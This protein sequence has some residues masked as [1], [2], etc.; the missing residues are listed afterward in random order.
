MEVFAEVRHLPGPLRADR[1]NE[2]CGE[3]TTV[4]SEV[5]SLLEH[6]DSAPTDML[7]ESSAFDDIFDD[8]AGTDLMPSCE[9]PDVIGGYRIKRIIGAG[10][11][12]VVYEAEQDKPRRAVAL[13]LVRSF[14]SPEAL[15][16]FELEGELLGRLRHPGIAR[17]FEAGTDTVG[18]LRRPFL[19]MELVVGANL[20]DHASGLDP[21]AKLDLIA[22][23]ADAVEHAHRRGV[24]HRDLK[25]GNILVDEAGQPVVLDFGIARVIDE[26][27]RGNSFATR[28]G[29]L[30]GTLPYM[31]PEQAAGDAEAVDTRTDVYALGAVAYELLAGR[32][33]I[34]T[35][36]MGLARAAE[37]VRDERPAPLSSL[38]SELGG[39][40]ETIV[41]CALEKDADRRYSSA[42]ELAADIRRFLSHK[43]ILARAPSR[44]YELKKFVRRH[45]V[46]V[47]LATAAALIL[48][49][50]IVTTT[51]GLVRAL[52]A[53]KLADDR[54][55]QAELALADAEA[56]ITFLDRMVDDS[57]RA[58]T[59]GRELTFSEALDQASLRLEEDV[60]DNP[61]V[62]ASIHAI[63]GMDYDTLEQSAKGL[64]HLRESWRLRQEH[65]GERHAETF[66]AAL[67]YGRVLLR[68]G[69]TDE[70]FEH[71]TQ[72][73]DLTPTL[74]DSHPNLVARLHFVHGEATMYR[75]DFDGAEKAMKMALEFYVE[76]GERGELE[77]ELHAGIA[78]SLRRQGR[79]REGEK[80]LREALAI[81]ARL[82]GVDSSQ[83][84]TFAGNL[85]INLKQQGRLAEAERMLRAAVEVK[86]RLFGA[87][88][89]GVMTH[90]CNLASLHL[91]L[92]NHRDAIEGLTAAVETHRRHL[93]DD[94]RNVGFPVYFLGRAHHEFGNYDEADAL[95]LEVRRIWDVQ[96]GAGH[97]RLMKCE[98][99][100]ARLLIDVGR[101]ERAEVLLRQVVREA[102]D[103]HPSD[104]AQ[105]LTLRAACA[106]LS[107]R[108]EEAED[109]VDRAL[110]I[111]GI[112]RIAA[113]S[114]AIERGWIALAD[115]DAAS[116]RG[117]FERAAE[118]AG[119][120]FTLREHRSLAA[121][122]HAR[123]LAADDPEAAIE[124]LLEDHEAASETLGVQHRLRRE[125]AELLSDLYRASGDEAAAARW[126]ERSRAG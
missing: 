48:L 66:E 42:G 1:L 63:F 9:Q 27:A 55:R 92:G 72:I 56:V 86:Q 94:H 114:L 82:K 125:L 74:A 45:R 28:E 118:G 29:V 96:M 2:L 112:G 19:A 106:R 33:P 98:L 15:R 83:H 69:N 102:G 22:R 38:H 40:V 16:R 25:P 10:G 121:L 18:G 113:V 54:R 34:S 115:G 68:S 75:G 58:V 53:E 79:L 99:D 93:G 71:L 103:D 30:V 52:D 62:L 57:S 3:A 85:A 43:P 110:A 61:R 50:G 20:V 11:M 105:A 49:A 120:E 8:D 109:L 87:G 81:A 97:P 35:E 90:E 117:H 39:D 126:A 17:V 37:A 80:H 70:G 104:L 64:V 73:L 89:A 78:A 6:H 84:S 46:P 101:L 4:R 91:A 116:A 23:V 24:I 12:G 107:D 36:G 60:G 88:S 100:H 26:E 76:H 108:I 32:R 119:A 14:G 95:M 67:H 47:V 123:A 77:A 5:E 65:L 31:S 13:K 21:A 111:D 7:D 122:G 41:H 124:R 59:N 51:L 44:T